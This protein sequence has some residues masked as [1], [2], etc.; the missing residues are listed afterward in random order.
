ML[1]VLLFSA[2]DVPPVSVSKRV[3]RNESE[4]QKV[5]EP[6]PLAGT[7]VTGT[8]VAMGGPFVGSVLGSVREQSVA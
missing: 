1:D 2:S 4:M 8:S 7:T 3:N 5:D 6:D